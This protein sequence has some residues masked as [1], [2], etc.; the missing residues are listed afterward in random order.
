MCEKCALLDKKIE[1]YQKLLLG[2]GDQLTV[3]IDRGFAGAEGGVSSRAKAVGRRPGVPKTDPSRGLRVGEGWGQ[4]MQFTQAI[5]RS[6]AAE[7]PINMST[8]CC[9]APGLC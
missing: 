4:F 6:A 9:R 2:I 8:F 3:V 1:H 7:S 5:R